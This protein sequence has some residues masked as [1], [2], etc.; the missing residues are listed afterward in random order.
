MGDRPPHVLQDR[1]VRARVFL[2]RILA[3]LIVLTQKLRGD[4]DGIQPNAGKI[5]VVS[6]FA[7]NSYHSH[8]PRQLGGF[9]LLI[10]GVFV[11]NRVIDVP[12]F[13]YT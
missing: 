2:R 11:Y 5:L 10:T 9:L 1:S 12:G 8:S 4:V 13:K 3:Q 7:N 6:S